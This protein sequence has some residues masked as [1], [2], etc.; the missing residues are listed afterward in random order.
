MSSLVPCFHCGLPVPA[1]SRFVAPVLGESREFCCPGCQAVAEAIVGGGLESYYR[2][3]SEPSANP[4]ALPQV[5][6]DEL[7]A[8]REMARGELAMAES[9]GGYVTAADL[10][11]AELAK[12]IAELE[13]EMKRAAQQLEF[14]RAAVLRDQ[15]MEMRQIM[16]LKEAG[17]KDDLPEWERMRRLD[18][19]G[20]AYEPEQ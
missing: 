8:Q 19:V 3:R 6:T 2:H 20:L 10:P 4:E 1:G 9:R 18:E 14:E 13:K 7:A 17:G 16:V 15:V 5:L 12:I 11:K